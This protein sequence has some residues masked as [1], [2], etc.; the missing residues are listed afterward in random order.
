MVPVGH[1]I[2]IVPLGD[3]ESFGCSFPRTALSNISATIL[4]PKV[5]TVERKN[6][7]NAQAQRFVARWN[8]IGIHNLRQ[9]R[10]YSLTI[11]AFRP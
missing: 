10:D 6:Q 4:R 9:F 1:T 8:L 2:K 5:H 3:R 7:N 11:G